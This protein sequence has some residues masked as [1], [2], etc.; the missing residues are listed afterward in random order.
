MTEV[1]RAQGRTALPSAVRPAKQWA[2]LRHHAGVGA[3]ADRTALRVAAA[4]GDSC[5]SAG[6]GTDCCQ[7]AWPFGAYAPEVHMSSAG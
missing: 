7:P 4:P 1:P 3:P 5:S 6:V 2:M